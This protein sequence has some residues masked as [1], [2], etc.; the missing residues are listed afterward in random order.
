ML[1]F[2][3]LAP[4]PWTC[5]TETRASIVDLSGY[6]FSINE[7]NCDAIGKSDRMSVYISHKGKSERALIFEYDPIER[8]PIPTLSFDSEGNLL[9]TIAS[10]A[11][12]FHQLH[13]W[14]ERKITYN[15]GKEYY[16]APERWPGER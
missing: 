9:I 16:P 13:E 7:T 12:V 2:L 5:L 11:T 3:D 15:I 1:A 4:T 14:R 8:N 6:D 10:V